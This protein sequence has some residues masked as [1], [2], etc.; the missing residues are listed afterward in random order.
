MFLSVAVLPLL[1][2]IDQIIDCCTL[3]YEEYLLYNWGFKCRDTAQDIHLLEAREPTAKSCSI[4]F[5]INEN[6][7]KEFLAKFYM[8]QAGLFLFF[9]YLY[10]YH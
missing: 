10:T 8:E 9:F 7:A 3:R 5:T 6:F 4:K 2:I 1:H